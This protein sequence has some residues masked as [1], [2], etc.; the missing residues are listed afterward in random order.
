MSF[1]RDRIIA[2]LSERQLKTLMYDLGFFDAREIDA[3]Q[4][5][6]LFLTS[7]EI[8]EDVMLGLVSLT[9]LRKLS[10][11][12]G[13]KG[14]RTRQALE[15]ALFQ[16][17][18]DGGKREVDASSEVMPSVDSAADAGV[19]GSDEESSER[20]IHVNHRKAVDIGGVI[21]PLGLMGCTN[22]RLFEK[23]GKWV[24][25]SYKS[26]RSIGRF[27]SEHQA[28]A[29]L[30]SFNDFRGLEH[31]R[32][33]RI[34]PMKPSEI[35]KAIRKGAKSKVRRTPE[36][37]RTE[38]PEWKERSEDLLDQ[39]YVFSGGGANGTGKRR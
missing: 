14:A 20:D 6:E 18:G 26:G 11:E 38:I 23:G 29:W 27:D 21:V 9:V 13:I 25:A 10:H 2:L 36:S 37:T 1:L 35:R 22:F 16:H 33:S 39:R 34:G 8:E 5:R 12:L 3:E 19:D 31:R 15:D 7:E 28:R 17:P 4:L 24:L 32:I 30:S